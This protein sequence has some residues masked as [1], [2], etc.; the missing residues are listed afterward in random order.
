MTA[1]PYPM[2]EE[3]IIIGSGPLQGSTYT[4]PPPYRLRPWDAL[5]H[6]H[7]VISGGQTGVD[8]AALDWAIASGV[9]HGGWCPRGRRAEDGPIPPQ[10]RLRE[11]QS[12]DYRQ[13]TRRNVTDSDSTLILNIGAVDGGTRLTVVACQD[14]GKPYRVIQLD[15]EAQ[16]LDVASVRAWL[17]NARVV[18]LN[19]AGPRERKRPGIYALATRYLDTLA[20]GT[21]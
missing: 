2:P 14:S 19:V 8:R 5:P 15:G 6:L 13:C 17:A 9:V 3:E 10:Y 21:I 4:P 1:K 11:M 16:R 12:S 18:V 7:C 20:T